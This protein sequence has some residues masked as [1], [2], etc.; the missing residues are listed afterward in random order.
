MPVLDATFVG[1]LYLPE[2]STGPLPPGPGQPPVPT[3]PIVIPPD[4]IGPG[5]PTHPIVLP[6]P[7]P[8]HPIVIP[9]G[10]LAPGVPTHPIYLPVYPEHPIVIPPDA[11]GPGLP[12]QPIGL[13]RPYRSRPC[14]PP[15]G[16]PPYPDQ[17]LPP[18]P[19]HPIVIP[20]D[21]IVPEPGDPTKAHMVVYYNTP[22]GPQ[23]IAFTVEIPPPTV[24]TEPAPK[25]SGTP[26]SPRLSHQR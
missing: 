17:G 12:P 6:P 5:V 13:R 19:A 15:V 1:K 22:Q 25:P 21:A 11:A 20:P 14:V 10:S 24:P 7:Y 8:S 3:H 4:A 2:V 16:S 23:R 26:Y 9:P 18:F